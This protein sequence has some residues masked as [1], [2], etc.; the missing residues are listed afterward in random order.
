MENPE[1]DKPQSV[2]KAI[3]NVMAFLLSALLMLIQ[4]G[5]AVQ[6]GQQADAEISASPRTAAQQV[7]FSLAD[8]H[9]FPNPEPLTNFDCSDKIYIV[10]ELA[11]YPPGRHELSIRWIDP[12]DTLREHTQYPFHVRE[13]TTRLW[14]W[15][16]LGRAQGAGML[17]WMNPAAGLEEFIGPWTTE[18]RVD[19]KK[20]AEPEFIVSC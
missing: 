16:S 7:Y 19:N 9:G 20:I 18:V 10:V 17:Q 14:A 2:K 12:A 11:D 3:T 15:L 13:R 6:A 1:A 5:Q 8:Q 4:S